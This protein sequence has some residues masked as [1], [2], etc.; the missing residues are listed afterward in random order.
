MENTD[1]II[2]KYPPARE[3]LLSM[4]HELQDADPGKY[5][6]EASLTRV[7]EYLQ[8]NKA[9]IKGVADYYSMLSQRPRKKLLLQ[10]CGSLMCH[11]AG[12]A[13]LYTRLRSRYG[14]HPLI[15][16]A[17]CECLGQCQQAPAVQLDQE[18]F[19]GA[20]IVELIRSIDK[21]TASDENS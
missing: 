3:Y 10:V 1:E 11:H 7:A 19:S 12:S 5:L 16:L 15:S 2:R 17:H 9:V 4:L 13:E 20:D 6:T 18:A 8:L 21:K 14:H